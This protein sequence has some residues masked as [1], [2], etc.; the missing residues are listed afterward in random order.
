MFEITI[1]DLE[2]GEVTEKQTTDGYVVICIEKDEGR[3]SIEKCSIEDI[4]DVIAV[5]GT[6]RGA[7][8]IG[9]AKW[10]AFRD[11]EEQKSKEK[12]RAIFEALSHMTDDE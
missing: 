3:T 1:K 8:R 5:N 6:L 10:D 7:A 4:S 2:T 9:I 12:A 11:H